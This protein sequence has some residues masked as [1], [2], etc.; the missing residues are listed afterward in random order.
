MIFAQVALQSGNIFEHRESQAQRQTANVMA[1]TFV[2]WLIYLSGHHPG[3]CF[4]VDECKQDASRPEPFSASIWK[5]VSTNASMHP[6][7]PMLKLESYK[8]VC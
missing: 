4:V 5:E 7:Q 2:T 3:K 8:A 1:G 6:G